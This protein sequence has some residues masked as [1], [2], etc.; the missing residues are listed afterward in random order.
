MCFKV[1]CKQCGKVTWGGCGKHAA[2]VYNSIE[3]GKHCTCRPWPGV[4]TPS[5]TSTATSSNGNKMNA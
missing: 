2:S 5:E 3:K 1:D 4:P